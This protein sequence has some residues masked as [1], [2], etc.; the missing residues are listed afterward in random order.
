MEEVR[1]SAAEIGA[2][3]GADGHTS[4][5]LDKVLAKS[6]LA[7]SGSDAQRKIKSGAVKVNGETKS[8][9]FLNIQLPAEIVLRVGR[10]MK[11]I[12]LS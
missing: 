7:E 4:L 5:K 10:K 2:V 3:A 12:V 8:E 9:L 1:F 11:K 6:G